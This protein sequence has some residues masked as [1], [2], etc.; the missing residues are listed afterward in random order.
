MTMPPRTPSYPL[1]LEPEVRSQLEVLAKKNG[2]SLNAQ[3]VL[4]IDSSLNRAEVLPVDSSLE[5]TISK[6]AREIVKEELTKA[7]IQLK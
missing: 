1:R 7:G 3:I 2:R 4:M 5:C 6:I